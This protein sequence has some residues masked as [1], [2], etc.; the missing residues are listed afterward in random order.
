MSSRTKRNLLGTAIAALLAVAAPTAQ[1]GLLVATASSCESQT[2]SQPFLP[3]AD[4]AS[5]T[6]DPGGSFEPGSPKW[7]VSG[8]RVVSGN[9][10]Y[11]VTDARDWRSLA[12]SDG[13][14]A[15]SP[16]LCVG[17]EHPDLR[18]FASTSNP[19]AALKVEVLYE[20]AAG[21]IRS[22]PIG[23]VTG[24]SG[25]APTVPFAIAA[26]LLPLMPGSYTAVSF[27]FSASG[28]SF[29]VDDVYV[30]PYSRY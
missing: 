11:N 22:L 19:S 5:Y 25:W 14:Q 2:L 8:A 3:W 1:A 13:G 4:V 16:S 6:L 30:D 18:F 29:Q 23:S 28:G 9:E 24:N 27:R 7:D 17:I 12:I 20:D 15:V 26:N 21:N 10:P